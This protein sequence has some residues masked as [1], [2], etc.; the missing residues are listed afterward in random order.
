MSTGSVADCFTDGDAV[1][2]DVEETTGLAP[3]VDF[4]ARELQAPTRQP[5]STT[6][7]IKELRNLFTTI[8]TTSLERSMQ[9]ISQSRALRPTQHHD[10]RCRQTAAS[11]RRWIDPSRLHRRSKYAAMKAENRGWR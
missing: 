5:S 9:R 2:F 6:I 8:T 7:K 3:V 11:C 4:A 1:T 10:R